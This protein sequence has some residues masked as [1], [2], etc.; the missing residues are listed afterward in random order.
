MKVYDERSPSC[1]YYLHFSDYRG[2]DLEL[3]TTSRSEVLM[4]TR[5]DFCV[6]FLVLGCFVER[7][8]GDFIGSCLRAD[9][10]L[11]VCLYSLECILVVTAALLWG[12][13]I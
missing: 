10:Q 5:V 4:R 13:T 3:L 6:W 8:T 12:P 9:Q 11:L 2:L 1:K 7:A